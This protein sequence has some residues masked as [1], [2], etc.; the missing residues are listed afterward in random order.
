[1]L[2]PDR[3]GEKDCGGA[4]DLR[5]LARERWAADHAEAA[6]SAAWAA[7]QAQP[8]DCDGKVLL[9]ALLSR[10]PGHIGADKKPALLKLLE[11]P[12]IDPEQIAA[13]GWF[14]MLRD[15]RLRAN[16]G[17]DREFGGH[18]VSWV[19]CRPNCGHW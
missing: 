6:L 14:L 18:R 4:S 11:D 3:S 7:Y 19:A 16:I 12:Q 2:D 15:D 1:M 5:R 9:T 8:D 17:A 13:A 10:Y